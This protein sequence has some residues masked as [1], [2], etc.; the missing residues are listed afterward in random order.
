MNEEASLICM[1]CNVALEPRK[2][3]FSY[4]GFQFSTIMP[5]C[6]LCG[7]VFVPEEVARGK[8]L[9]TELELESK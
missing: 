6:P 8:M 5:R 9:E 3:D 7:L 2:T 4:M 1:K